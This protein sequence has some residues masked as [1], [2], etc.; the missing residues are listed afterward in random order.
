ME[1]ITKLP[2]ITQDEQV[3]FTQGDCWM[4]AIEMQKR[5]SLPIAFFGG[6]ESNCKDEEVF[7]VHAFNTLPNGDYID[8]MGVHTEKEMESD[9]NDCV[10]SGHLNRFV[11]ATSP[12]MVH[13]MVYDQIPA[14]GEDVTLAAQKL[15]ELHL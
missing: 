14:Y 3:A 6:A 11:H 10:D 2:A 5:Y 12:K 4:L 7:W 9:W 8:I 1:C 13:A 15:A